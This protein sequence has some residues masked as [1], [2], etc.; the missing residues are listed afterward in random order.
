MISQSV[1]NLIKQMTSHDFVREMTHEQRMSV[2]RVVKR[3]GRD[4]LVTVEK[5]FCYDT[6]LLCFEH[7]VIGVEPDGYAH[8]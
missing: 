1:V 6:V 7:I 8:S 4:R 3:Q 2:I 5:E